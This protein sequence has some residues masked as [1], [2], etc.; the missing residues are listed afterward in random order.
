MGSMSPKTNPPRVALYFS[1]KHFHSVVLMALV[2]ADYKFLTV[3]FGVPG[4]GS[5]GRIFANMELRVL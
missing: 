1:Y 4:E 2:A 5:D 3:D